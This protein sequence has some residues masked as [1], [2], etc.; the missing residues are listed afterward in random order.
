MKSLMIDLDD[1]LVSFTDLFVYKANKMISREKMYKHERLETSDFTTYDL[2]SG[3]EKHWKNMPP[4]NQQAI[5]THCFNEIMKDEDLYDDIQLS[6]DYDKIMDIAMKYK[7]N[8]YK[9]V[10]NT[11]VITKEM[12]IAKSKFIH[13]N[14]NLFQGFDNIVLDYETGVIEPKPYYYDVMIDDSPKNIEYY[15]E[16][17]KTGMAYMPK[18]CWNKHLEGRER[19]HFI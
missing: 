5:Y 9:I 11:K 2:K 18:R 3:F 15:L 8:G 19:I 6:Q 17:N 10:L 13:E 1:T 7:R 16:K 4:N 12:L 14:M